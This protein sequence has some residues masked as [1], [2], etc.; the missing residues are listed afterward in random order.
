MK[1]EKKLSRPVVEAI[2]LV[3]QMLDNNYA[4]FYS[5]IKMAENL[6]VSRNSLQN[7]FRKL[8]GIN[9][10]EYKKGQSMVRAR[11]LLQQGKGIKEVS[12]M[13]NYSCQ[14]NFTRAFK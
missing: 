5:V 9:L 8:Y 13:L 11:Q 10:R 6:G 7:G 1:Q 3:K 14:A 2:T 4:D 12:I